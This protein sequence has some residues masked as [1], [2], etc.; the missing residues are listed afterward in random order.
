[1]SGLNLLLDYAEERGL[2]VAGDYYGEI[3]AETPA[4]HYEGRE[5]LYKL[6]VPVLWTTKCE[7]AASLE[8]S[9]RGGRRLWAQVRRV[10]GR[11]CG[12]LPGGLVNRP[13]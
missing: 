12:R 13:S 9:A 8:A 10:F 2:T 3:I 1:M 4:F 7:G 11:L 5:M 6:E